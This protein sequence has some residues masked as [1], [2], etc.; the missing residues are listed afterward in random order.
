MKIYSGD[1]QAGQGDRD[2]QREQVPQREAAG[3]GGGDRPDY[4]GGPGPEDSEN[5]RGQRGSGQI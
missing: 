3:G 2:Q 1:G 5:Q 4:A